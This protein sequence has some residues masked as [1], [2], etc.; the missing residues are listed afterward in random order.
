[1]KDDSSEE[2]RAEVNE[3]AAVRAR[4]GRRGKQDEAKPS[5]R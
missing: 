3:Q 4:Q 2:V 5:R 1:M